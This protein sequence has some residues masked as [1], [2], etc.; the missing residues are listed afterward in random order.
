M[1]RGLSR[2]WENFLVPDTRTRSSRD[3]HIHSWWNRK[4]QHKVL[5]RPATPGPQLRWTHPRVSQNPVPIQLLWSPQLA[6][7]PCQSCYCPGI[8]P[9][10][11]TIPVCPGSSRYPNLPRSLLP[12]SQG[13]STQGSHGSVCSRTSHKPHLLLGGSAES[14][15]HH[16]CRSSPP[17]QARRES[18][19][20]RKRSLATHP[21]SQGHCS[22]V[23]SPQR[24][25]EV[26]HA[27]A[28][29]GLWGCP[30]S[31]SEGE[32]GGSVRELHTHPVLCK[33]NSSA[34]D[35]EPR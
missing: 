26:D 3:L 28:A 31:K 17:P 30:Q 35:P 32:R 7:D 8:G 10:L 24:G 13:T 19:I 1:E 12:C 6:L 21:G 27:A 14:P 2:T 23:A 4:C 9:P 20:A 15:P 18:K 16:L 33:V 22:G 34:W 11:L 25:A 5:L 29:A